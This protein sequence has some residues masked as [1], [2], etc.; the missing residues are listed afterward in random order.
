MAEVKALLVGCQ[1]MQGYDKA[2]AERVTDVVL[3]GLRA[4]RGKGDLSLHSPWASAKNDIGTR[5]R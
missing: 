1:A 4:R 2:R 5:D 3:D